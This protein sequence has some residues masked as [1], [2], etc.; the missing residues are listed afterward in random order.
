[1][2]QDEK[3]QERF[4]T[5]FP[6]HDRQVGVCVASKHPQPLYL[7]FEFLQIS[8]FQLRSN[9][10]GEETQLHRSKILDSI[11]HEAEDHLEVKQ[12]IGRPERK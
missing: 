6:I 11:L 2:R 5:F 12:K 3:A 10:K 1:M 7:L 4:S 9:G 8:V